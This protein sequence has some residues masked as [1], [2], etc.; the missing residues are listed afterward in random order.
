MYKFYNF[1]VSQHSRRVHALFEIAG[2]E[3]ESVHVALDKGEYLSEEYLAINPNHQVPTLIDGDIK[4]HESNAILRYIC[5]KHDLDDWY[6]TDLKKLTLVEQWLDWCQCRLSPA[7]IN[8]VLFT[9]FMPE[10]NNQEAIKSGHTMMKELAP[11]LESGLDGKAYLSGEMPTIADLAVASNI[12]HLGFADAVPKS[13]NI[14]G[15]LNR[16]C[17]IPGFKKTLPEQIAS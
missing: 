11:I 16:V 5:R 15:W 12:T 8:I 10:L 1:P 6:P 4:I 14:Q 3:F 7:V 13:P 17:S 9:V 2:I